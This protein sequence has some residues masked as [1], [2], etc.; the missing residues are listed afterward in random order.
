MRA[1]SDFHSLFV[2]DIFCD[3]DNGVFPSMF[4]INY[5]SAGVGRTGTF[6]AFDVLVKQAAEENK[7]DIYGWIT[8]LRNERMLMVQTKVNT[9]ILQMVLYHVVWFK[10][11]LPVYHLL[12]ETEK[13]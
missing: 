11:V 7:V 1:L 5:F 10:M 9:V 12:K 3:D 8:K 13:Q 2:N 4:T 6:I